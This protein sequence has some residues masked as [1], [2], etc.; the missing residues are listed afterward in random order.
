MIR[1]HTKGYILLTL[2]LV[3]SI[4]IPLLMVFVGWSVTSLRVVERTMQREVAFHIAEAGIEYYRWHLAHNPDDFQDGTDTEGPYVHTVADKNGEDIGTFSLDIDPPEIGSTI[5][6]ITSTGVAFEDPI[7][8]RSVRVRLARPSLA[9]F[10]VV[11]NSSMRFGEGTE[12]FG[13]VHANG[14][15]R[16]DGYAHNIMTS[17]QETYNDTDSDACTVSS[18]G[19]HTCLTPT[20]PAPIITPTDR[21]DVFSAGRTFPV[22]QVDFAG[23]MNDLSEIKLE[24]QSDGYYVGPSGSRGYRILLKTNGTFDVYRVTSVVS[25]PSG[26]ASSQEDWGTWS[27]HQQTLVGSYAYPTNGLIFVEDNVWVEGQIDGQKITIAAGAFP[28]NASTRKSIIVNNDVRYTAYDGTDIIALIAQKDISVGMVSYTTLHIDGALVAQNGRVG[29]FY[30]AAPSGSQ[31]RCSPYHYR[32]EIVLYGMIA[33]HNRYGFA[34]TNGTGYD[35]RNITYDGNLLYTPPP[36]FPLTGEFYTVL[37]W[38]EVQ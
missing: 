19:V 25:T 4:V 15:I 7:V 26:C 1:I 14:G 24:A 28:D 17:S 27:V 16:F 21:P 35:I 32:S 23:I 12:V 9:Q 2:I 20:D 33:T 37:S 31:S 22:P 6:T 5:V 8:S 11:A 30:Y 10:A 38:E 18:W 3:L 36:Y 34:Y 29:R 13:P